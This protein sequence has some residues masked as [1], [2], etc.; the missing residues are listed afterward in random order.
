MFTILLLTNY[1]NVILKVLFRVKK[2]VMKKQIVFI[3]SLF[4]LFT[5]L[6]VSAQADKS[7]RPSP[8]AIVTETIKSGVKITVDYSQ[9]SVKGRTIGK[10]IAPFGKVWRTGANEATV[11]EITKAVKVNGMDLP[12]GKYSL[13]S[14]PTE[15]EW[16]VIFNKS[17]KQSGTKYDEAQDA[18]RIKVKPTASKEF[19]EKMTFTIE[20]SGDVKLHWGNVIVPFKVK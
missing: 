2:K 8:P 14:I 19:V 18:L 6:Q 5:T 7:K 1:Q 15:T 20:K 13:Y 17:W 16:T 4:I 9:P 3:A 11:F 12:A 10:E